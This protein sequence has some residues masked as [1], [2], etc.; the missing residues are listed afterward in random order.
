MGADLRGQARTPPA[1]LRA[2]PRP[3]DPDNRAA[4]T[5]DVQTARWPLCETA[6][7]TGPVARDLLQRWLTERSITL[8]FIDVHEMF[9]TTAHPF[10]WLASSPQIMDEARITH[11]VPPKSRGG[12]AGAAQKLLDTA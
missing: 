7:S 6:R 12:N 8:S 11:G 1:P 3:T 9:Y 5:R 10:A 4:A 2:V